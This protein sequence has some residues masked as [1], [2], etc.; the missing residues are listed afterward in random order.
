MKYPE[1]INLCKNCIGCQRLEDV[2]FKGTYK[3]EYYKN[4]LS[5]YENISNK[6]ERI[7]L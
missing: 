6:Q 5:L 7:K 1:L 4:S 3:F 2:N